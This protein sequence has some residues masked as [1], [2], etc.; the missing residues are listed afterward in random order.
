MISDAKKT[1]Q[2][3]FLVKLAALEKAKVGLKRIT[4]WP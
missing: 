3:L 2:R 4:P 1:H